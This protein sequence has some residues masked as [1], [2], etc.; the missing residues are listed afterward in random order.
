MKKTYYAPEFIDVSFEARKDDVLNPFSFHRLDYYLDN[1][2][3]YTDCG[4]FYELFREAHIKVCIRGI[5]V[6][7]ASEKI[8]SLYGIKNPTEKVAKMIREDVE[9]GGLKVVDV[10]SVQSAI[11]ERKLA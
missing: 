9:R 1:G 7:D 11:F 8:L 3:E 6:I 5:E 4:Y 10:G 2:Y